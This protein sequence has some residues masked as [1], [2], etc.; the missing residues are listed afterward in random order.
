MAIRIGPGP[1]FVFEW[2]TSTR[3]WQLYV[4]RSDFVAAIL[5]GKWL[6]VIRH[7]WWALAWPVGIAG[8]PATGS[9]YWLEFLA[10]PGLTFAYAA[11]L[12]SLGPA[13][14]TWV[15]RIARAVAVCIAAF[16]LLSFGWAVLIVL[17]FTPEPLGRYVLMG[18]PAY[19]GLLA[20]TILAPGPMLITDSKK[21]VIAAVTWTPIHL[22]L[23]AALFVMTLATFDRGLGRISKPLAHRKPVA[24]GLGRLK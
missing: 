24:G 10:F 17:R 23:A 20:T 14:R 21:G 11:V 15:I 4:Q 16:V 22:G 1:V 6:G 18:T 9:G 2:Q 3:R 8:L 12:T 7:A 13:L 5:A 19:G